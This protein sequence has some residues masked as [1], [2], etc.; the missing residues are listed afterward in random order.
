[1]VDATWAYNS[2][3]KITTI[4]TP[5]ELVYGKKDLLS[6]EF[7]LNTLRMEAELNL[8]LSNAQ[9]ER[10]LQLNGLDKF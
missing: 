6:V 4:F 7:E 3:W 8:D 1:M 5:S 2:I 10:L 9:K